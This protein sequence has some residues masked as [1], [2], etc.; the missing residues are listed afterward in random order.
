MRSPYLIALAVS[1]ADSET[2]CARC[3]QDDAIRIGLCEFCCAEVG[4][5]DDPS[6]LRP[7]EIA[8]FQGIRA[9]SVVE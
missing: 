9:Q 1:R 5:P 6:G 4:V 3:G 7:S 8:A 2:A